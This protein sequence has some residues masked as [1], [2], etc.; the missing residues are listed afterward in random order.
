MSEKLRVRFEKRAE[1]DL[2]KLSKT[3]RVLFQ[4][5]IAAVES[6]R[7]DPSIGDPKQGDLKGFSCLD[8]QHQRTNYEIAY[9]LETDED[10]NLVAVIMIGTRENFYSNLKRYI[11]RL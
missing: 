4:K 10:G 11:G 6:I 9:R 2:K 8:V 3:D 5:I 7:T 1:K